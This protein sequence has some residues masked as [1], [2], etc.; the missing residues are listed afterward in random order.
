M[1]SSPIVWMG[2]KADNEHHSKKKEKHKK[3]QIED[4]VDT[5]REKS[6][7]NSPRCVK[8]SW[9][10]PAARRGY[11]IDASH[12]EFISQLSVTRTKCLR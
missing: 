6:Y 5:G 3:K 10:S 8:Y 1:M 2:P 11:K 9:Q 4:F 12:S 7:V